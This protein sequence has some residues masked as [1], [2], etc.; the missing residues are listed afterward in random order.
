MRPYDEDRELNRYVF[1]NYRGFLSRLESRA[2]IV[3]IARLKGSRPGEIVSL[4]HGGPEVDALLADG[5][6]AF[7]MRVRTRILAEHSAEIFLNRCPNC[8]RLVR[9]PLAKQCL[10]CGYDWHT[11]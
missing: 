3:A 9:T 11:G 8:H 10:W 5:H 6:D 7:Q 2:D 4:Q 1:T